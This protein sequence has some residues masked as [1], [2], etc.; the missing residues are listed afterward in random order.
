VTDDTFPLT[1]VFQRGRSMA[2]YTIE[3]VYHKAIDVCIAVPVIAC[4]R[5]VEPV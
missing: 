2:I 5:T 4:E 1:R 3:A